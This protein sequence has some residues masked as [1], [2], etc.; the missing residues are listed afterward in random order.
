MAG[1]N[2]KLSDD[3]GVQVISR[4]FGCVVIETVID[5]EVFQELHQPGRS[6]ELL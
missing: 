5:L 6:Q 2:W 4:N 1:E 3:A